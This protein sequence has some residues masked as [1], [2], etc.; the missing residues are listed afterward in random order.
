RLGQR[1]N[2]LLEIEDV[3]TGDAIAS[4]VPLAAADTLVTTRAER[5]I[6]RTGEDDHPDLGILP[7][8]VERRAQLEQCLGPER[9]PALRAV[10]G[11]LRDAVPLFVDDVLVVPDLLPLWFRHW[12]LPSSLSTSGRSIHGA[13]RKELTSL[14]HSSGD[15]RCGACPAPGKT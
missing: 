12:L 6:A 7:G 15:S 11:D 1:A 4:D 13:E 5:L 14:A 2:L 8:V 3:E 9:G 10:D